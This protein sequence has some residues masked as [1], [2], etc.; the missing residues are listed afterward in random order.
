MTGP[1]LTVGGGMGHPWLLA[2]RCFAAAGCCVATHFGGR[3][4]LCW[5][6]LLGLVFRFQVGIRNSERVAKCDVAR[7]VWRCV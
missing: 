2:A 6:L 5:V 1:A 7:G 4:T 3:A